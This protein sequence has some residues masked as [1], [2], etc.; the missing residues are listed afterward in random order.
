VRLRTI[1]LRADHP[2]PASIT[3][4]HDTEAD[5]IE[6]STTPEDLTALDPADSPLLVVAVTAPE[7]PAP[8]AGD[9]A[10]SGPRAPELTD[11]ARRVLGD[12]GATLLAALGF[13]AS[14]AATVRLAAP[15]GP[16]AGRAV[17]VVGLGPASKVTLETLRR[18]AGAAVRAAGDVVALATD[19]ATL[20]LGQ[21][22]APARLAAVVEGLLLGDY[23]YDA[24][25]S[26]PS[27]RRLARAAV[28]GVAD[29]DAV[30][31]RA[32]VGAEAAIWVRDLVNTSP[33]DKR[34]PVLADTVVAGLA[35][36]DVAVRVLDEHELAEG[37][38]GG[39]LG[40]GGG[41]TMKP[42]LVELRWQ[43]E[44]AQR[45]V[46]LVGKGIT[47]D[48]GGYSLKP[49]AGQ[50]TMKMDMAGAATAAA[51]VRAAAR[52]RLPV[53]VT[54]VLALAEN[55]VSGDAQR[56]SDVIRMRNGTTVEVL[57]TDAE[58]RLVLGDGLAHAIELG[59]DTVVDIATL[60]GAVIVALGD[61]IG[62]VMA[63]DDAL[64]A[65]LIATG[66]ANGEP[67]WQ[68]PLAVDEY[69]KRVEGT[70]ADLRNVGNGKDPGTVFGALFLARFVPD[71]VRW[72]HLD[73]AG[74]AWRDTPSPYHQKGGTGSPVRTLV[75]WLEGLS[76][77]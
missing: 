4:I 64:A 23:R 14:E 56:V 69:G 46:A 8:D 25:R 30:V 43:P 57:N 49:T 7:P 68:L 1:T 58:G 19:L 10:P 53:A 20:E 52:L 71:R 21:G 11:G 5:V 16:V 50:E 48:T 18:A 24:Y 9:E 38:Y 55:L 17:L 76:R 33:K 40:V 27:P 44:G 77:G 3:R 74:I 42:R 75:A 61:L 70:F 29:G 12:D 37:G 6:I 2:S 15:V 35:D 28:T 60:T 36:D 59:A 73:I 66:R 47:F 65:E 67:L 41:S 63:N 34:P 31:E 26:K 51:V 62:G 45:H 22:D 13:E 39:I 72:A 54:A 32:R